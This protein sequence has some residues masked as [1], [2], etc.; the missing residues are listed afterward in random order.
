M[1]AALTAY[2]E[3]IKRVHCAAD[4][5]FNKY[6]YICCMK[7]DG[8][9]ISV[10]S[11][12]SIAPDAATKREG[13]R[14]GALHLLREMFGD[15]S[16]NIGHDPN[17]APYLSNK[18]IFISVSH[19]GDMVAVAASTDVPIGIDIQTPSPKLR[20]VASKFLSVADKVDISDDLALLQAWTI[21]EAVYKAALTP[22][23]N[24]KAIIIKRMSVPNSLVEVENIGSF[25]CFS[26][27]LPNGAILTIAQ[28][29]DC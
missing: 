8:I 1:G 27:N 17:G 10:G 11:I 7:C 20:R 29:F 24:L 14:A 3:T 23:L 9:E 22:G 5:Y 28:I 2:R 26:K 19:S 4:K 16:V 15:P 13:E 18:N 21:K 25:K 12:A 6:R